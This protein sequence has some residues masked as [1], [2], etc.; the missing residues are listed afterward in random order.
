M[1]GLVWLQPRL[2]HGG[3]PGAIS[4]IVMTTNTAGIMG[5]LTSTIVAWLLVG[6]PDLGMSINGLLAGLVAITPG[7][8]YVSVASSL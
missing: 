6:K 8:A 5:I 3:G 1:A 4:H 7:C 2:D